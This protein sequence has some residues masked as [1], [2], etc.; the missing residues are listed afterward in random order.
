M[1]E[2]VLMQLTSKYVAY[3]WND[4][5]TRVNGAMFLPLNKKM[6]SPI[7]E[8]IASNCLKALSSK[9]SK[10]LKQKLLKASMNFEEVCSIAIEK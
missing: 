8:L 5:L 10:A 1:E 6:S 4:C 9:R 3:I 2:P 7:S